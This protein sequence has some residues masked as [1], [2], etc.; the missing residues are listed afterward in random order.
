MFRRILEIL[1]HPSP[2]CYCSAPVCSTTS[3]QILQ[4]NI[5]WAVHSTLSIWCFHYSS[6]LCMLPSSVRTMLMRQ[7][8]MRMSLDSFRNMYKISGRTIRHCWYLEQRNYEEV[9]VI[10]NKLF[11]LNVIENLIIFFMRSWWWKLNNKAEVRWQIWRL[12][13]YC[14]K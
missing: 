12:C 4:I 11:V 14:Q 3:K 9:K 13:Y 10:Y 1:V 5:L 7:I 8:I 6:S 2:H